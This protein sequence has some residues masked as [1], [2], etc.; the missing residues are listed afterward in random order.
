MADMISEYGRSGDRT[1]HNVIVRLAG[2]RTVRVKS[3]GLREYVVM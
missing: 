2:M 3:P 1:L